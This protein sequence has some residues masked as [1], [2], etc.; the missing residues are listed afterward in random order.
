[1][2]IQVL[3]E[4]PALRVTMVMQ[5]HPGIQDNQETKVHKDLLVLK[6]LL[7]IVETLDYLELLVN[8]VNQE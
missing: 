6:D 4:M 5:V 8:R 7:E 2:V 3:Q 1:M